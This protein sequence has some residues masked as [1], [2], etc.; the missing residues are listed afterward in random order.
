MLPTTSAWAVDTSDNIQTTDIVYT[1]V[2]T[3][4]INNIDSKYITEG[5]YG[6]GL[7]EM[8]D[9][10]TVPQAT[11][12]TANIGLP[13]VGEM[14]SGNDI[15]LSDSI[16]KTFIDVNTIE[17]PT[18]STSYWTMNLFGLGSVVHNVE[19][20]GRLGNAASS[21]IYLKSAL[22]FSNGKGTAQEPYEL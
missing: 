20:T 6:V 18:V 11:T 9:N 19:L 1:G 12:T 10:Y 2:L 5:T 8:K 21:T 7:Y 22:T 3:P 13:T 4:F 14:F 15:D 17:N 16:T